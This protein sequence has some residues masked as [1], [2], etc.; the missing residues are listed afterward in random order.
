MKIKMITVR[1]F[2][3]IL[4]WKLVINT[5][6]MIYGHGDDHYNFSHIRMNFSS[7]VNPAGINSGLQAY[8]KNRIEKL[9]TYPEPLAETLAARIEQRKGLPH[10]S[11]I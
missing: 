8:L 2:V 11:F 3:K 1:I 10:C 6:R 4:I 5:G 7:N 9:D